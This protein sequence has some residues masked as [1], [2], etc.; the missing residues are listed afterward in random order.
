[1]HTSWGG[2]MK[3]WNSTFFI[4]LLSTSLLV[5][6]PALTHASSLNPLNWISCNQ[7]IEV[8][9]DYL[10]WK[11]CIDD[12][13]YA[14]SLDLDSDETKVDYKGICPEW[15]SGFR[16]S[17]ELP[18]FFKDWTLSTSYTFLNSDTH[19]HIKD[20]NAPDDNDPDEVF[21]VASPLVH[22]AVLPEI[23]FSSIHCKYALN[24]REWDVLLHYE[25]CCAPNHSFSPYFGVAGVDLNQH[26]KMNT[27]DSGSL[28][29]KSEYRGVGLRAGSYYTYK[30]DQCFS[31]F[32][33]ANGTLVVGNPHTKNRQD[34]VGSIK[35]KDDDCCLFVPGYHITAGALYEI[36]YCGRE[37]SFRCGYEFVNWYN[38]PNPRIFSS[39]GIDTSEISNSTSPN[40]RTIGFHGILAGISLKF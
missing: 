10:R 31:L 13:D 7:H 17:L 28:R 3:K 6:L 39:N 14:A 36:C 22:P 34:F 8:E 16:V 9:A 25:I 24:Y 11:P 27:S 4:T 35:F 21:K 18:C 37:Y 15:E 30:I 2:N 40:T 38:T 5:F 33:N 12:L 19:S 23:L 1:M 32:A 20:E 29:W 26:L